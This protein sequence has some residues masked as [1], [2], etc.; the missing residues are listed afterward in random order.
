MCP[1]CENKISF[2]KMFITLIILCAFIFILAA[3]NKKNVDPMKECMKTM[4]HM[5]CV[6]KLAKEANE[7]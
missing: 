7:D 6:K 5:S 1:N 4:D 2:K 3:C